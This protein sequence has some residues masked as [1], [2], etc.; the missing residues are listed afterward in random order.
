MAWIPVKHVLRKMREARGW[1]IDDLIDKTGMSER[2]LNTLESRDPP[3][4]VRPDTADKVSAAFG[5]KLLEHKH[6]R[7][8]D[9]WIVWKAH[10]K[11]DEPASGDPNLRQVG[12]IAR[13]AKI[14]RGLDLHA[15][16]LPTEDGPYELLGLDRLHK[17]FTQPK[18]Y[19]GRVFVVTGKVDQHA[20]LPTSAARKIGAKPDEG[21]VYRVTRNVSKRCP[22]YTTVFAPALDL[23]Q[24]LMDAFDSAEPVA[25]VVR[26]VYAPP[27][28]PWRGFFF[29][30]DGPPK[31][32]KFALVVD[33]FVAVESEK[34]GKAS[35]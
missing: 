32:K 17:C 6:W 8:D 16:T 2:Q 14:E 1:C 28:G 34:R 19:E 13:L 3:S 10:T 15:V 26:V 12:T 24:H 29:I 22:I 21:A 9:Q 7:T 27:E 25:L 31:S 11:D 30:E 35:A 18:L 5:L 23:S 33:K 20:A 4:F